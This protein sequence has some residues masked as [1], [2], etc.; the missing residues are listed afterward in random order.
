MALGQQEAYTLACA[1]AARMG[2]LFVYDD[3]GLLAT[4]VMASS[5]LGTI[6]EPVELARLEERQTPEVA[7]DILYIRS[8]KL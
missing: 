3:A 7:P 6:E 2:F 4:P 1:W 5:T 8:I